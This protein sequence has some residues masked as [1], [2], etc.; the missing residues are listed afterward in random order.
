MHH[1]LH[2]LHL[3]RVFGEVCESVADSLGAE[4]SE[5]TGSILGSAGGGD[6]VEAGKVV[7][8]EDVLT[9]AEVLEYVVPTKL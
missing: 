5:A 3:G 7:V 2:V 9:C 6:N 1:I 8:I 4:A